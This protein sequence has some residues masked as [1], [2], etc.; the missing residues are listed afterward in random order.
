MDSGADFPRRL[1]QYL[2][3]CWTERLGE[4]NVGH[5]ALAEE[6]A[7]PSPGA[8]DKLVG[9][10]QVAGLDFFLETARRADG[11]DM[12]HSQ[13]FKGI[14][15]GSR[16]QFAGQD[17]VPLTVARQKGEPHPLQLTGDDGIT[18]LTKRGIDIDFLNIRHPLNIIKPRPPN[19][20][21]SSLWHE[22]LLNLTDVTSFCKCRGG[23]RH[24]L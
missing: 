10:K 17:A 8:V 16:W 23:G 22:S 6:G 12:L 3:Q 13:R 15:I 4:R 21:D 7:D 24:L 19:H 14:D 18:R 1:K 9:D 2:A 5:D 20:P 11:D